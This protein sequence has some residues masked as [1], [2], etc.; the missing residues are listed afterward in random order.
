MR[1][2]LRN[3]WQRILCHQTL[4]IADLIFLMTK[5]DSYAVAMKKT[6][7]MQKRRVDKT[8]QKL[9]DSGNWTSV[10]AFKASIEKIERRKRNR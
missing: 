7:K 1:L 9:K 4:A 3:Q 10:S 6:V 2:S 5:E 8:I